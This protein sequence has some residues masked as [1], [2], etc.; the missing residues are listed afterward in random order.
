MNAVDRF[1]DKVDVLDSGCWRWTAFT[2][3]G[4][5]RMTVDG[6]SIEMHRWAYEQFIGHIPDGLHLD[7]ICHT[8]D[9]SCL[10]GPTCLHRRC[11]CPWH[12]EPVT[13]GEN[14]LR[15]NT[16]AAR[17]KAQRECV[18]GHPFDEANTYHAKNG[19]RMCRRCRADSM[20]RDRAKKRAAA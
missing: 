16:L 15:G 6:Q 12:L 5:A 11:V 4:Y 9:P 1:L 13:I 14:T 10:G 7:H 3:K 17:K 20:V 2:H 8:N 18:N 19:T